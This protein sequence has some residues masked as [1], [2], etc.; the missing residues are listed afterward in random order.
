MSLHESVVVQNKSSL[1]FNFCKQI[2]F[3]LNQIV[4]DFASIAFRL[5]EVDAA[6]HWG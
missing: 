5:A 2:P 1:F 3:L 6:V 4:Y